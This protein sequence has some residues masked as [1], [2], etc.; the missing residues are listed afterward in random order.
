MLGGRVVSEASCKENSPS[1]QTEEWVQFRSVLTVRSWRV[2]ELSSTSVAGC[3]FMHSEEG[4]KMSAEDR[5][6]GRA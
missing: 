6:Q 1:G 5:E 2:S 3:G 4:Q